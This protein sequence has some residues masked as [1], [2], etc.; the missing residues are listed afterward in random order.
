[1]TRAER[2]SVFMISM[3]LLGVVFF[4][5]RDD[6]EL[7][8]SI[9]TLVF[10]ALIMISFASLFIE[11]YFTTPSDVLANTI[12]ILL[13]LAPLH[14]I[15]GRMGDAYWIFFSYNLVFAVTALLAL[16][17][18][19][20][21]K[22]RDVTTNRI[23]D[24]LKR[25]ST[26]FANGRLL[27]FVLFVLMMLFYVELRSVQFIVLFGYATLILLVDPK[28][29]SLGI[30]KSQSK[31][32]QDVGEIIAVH[33]ENTFL[34]K[35]YSDRPALRRF[36][37][38]E[39]RYSMSEEQGVRVGLVID[40][41]LLNKE[42]WIKILCTPEI[43]EQ[44]QASND[45]GALRAN[46]VNK[47]A[48]EAPP[49]LLD[50][51]VGVVQE[52]S[53]I[54]KVQ[55]EFQDKAQV[56]E[57]SLIDV[58]A[59]GESILYQVVQATTETEKLESKDE[60]GYIVG[61][62]IQLGKWDGTKRRFDKF[63]WVP[64]MN[65]PVFVAPDIDEIPPAADEVLLGVIPNTNYP[66][67]L[68]K[69]D[70]ITHHLAILGVTGCG[71]S[72]L[73]REL[74]REIAADGTKVICIDFTNEYRGK[75]PE[76]D[77]ESIVP[78][79]LSTKLFSAIDSLS[80]EL[81]KFRN[82]QDPEDIEAWEKELHDAFFDSLK[83]FL[84]SEK[85]ISFFELPDVSNTTGIFAYTRW[86]FRVLFEIARVHSNFGKRI[87]IVLEE[88]HT[89]IPEWTFIGASEKEAGNLVNNISQIALQGRKYDVGFIV[90]AQRTANVSKT[91]LTQCNSIIAFQQ[92]DKTGQEFLSNY[93]GSEMV[94][95]LPNLRFRQAIV[96]GKGFQS[97]MP[98]IVDVKEITE[99][100]PTDDGEDSGSDSEDKAL[101]A[102]IPF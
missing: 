35:L 30:L 10:S 91:V 48:V 52:G 14:V 98:V 34:A 44:L 69:T 58:S 99:P 57:G 73:A 32:K 54:G 88:A 4:F 67:F 65:T 96:V 68:S 86:F 23:S 94:Q 37:P 83:A 97:G 77:P 93:M 8:A 79:A 92:F 53:T 81:S 25:I 76:F 90:I 13:V 66:V 71:K 11:H 51:Y 41:Y 84:E 75:F 49:E 31:R 9:T 33:S 40:K 27:Y 2:I 62:A 19:D 21:N 59:D 102:E 101:E 29:M 87:C 18:F 43:E 56:G 89:V 28:R 80:L 16:L 7:P 6:L 72:V 78:E 100:Q 45:A 95:T 1:M 17:L 12:S 61:E 22:S 50:R 55:F 82:Q 74:I 3:A 47:L 38:V 36:D 26:R 70:A 15:L 64:A 60:T 63:G 24:F 39:F 20:A 46:V 42:Q 5:L 85:P